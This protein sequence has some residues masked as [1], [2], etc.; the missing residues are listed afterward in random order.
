MLSINENQLSLYMSLFRGRSDVYAKRWQKGEKTWYM[1][2][3]SFNW[4]EYLRHKAQGGNFKNF[5]RKTK[6]PLTR[7]VIRRHLAGTHFIG[8]YPLLEDNTSYFIAADF[9]RKDWISDSKNFLGQCNLLGI[10]AYIEKSFSG[11]GAHLWIFFTEKYPAVKSRRIFLEIIRKALN[12]S[13]FAKQVSFDRVFPN[14]DYHS[15]KGFGNLIALPLNGKC[16]KEGRTLFLDPEDFQPVVDQWNYLNKINKVSADKLDKLYSEIIKDEEPI[17][18]SKRI[19]DKNLANFLKKNL[20]FINSEYIV[21]QKIGRSV[22]GI[23]KFFN[24]ITESKEFI[25][26]PRGFLGQLTTFCEENKVDYR[27]IDNRPNSGSIEFKSKIKLSK[28]QMQ[29]IQSCEH[30]Q[31]GV[32]VAP[33]G[34]GKTIIGIELIARKC[35]PSLIIVHRRQIYDQWIERIQDFL[36]LNK[37]DIGQVSSNKKKVSKLI[38]VAMIQSLKRFPGLKDISES[39]GTIIIDEC[40]HIPAKS[41]R[42]TIVNFNPCYIYGLTATPKRKYNDEKMIFFYIGDIICNIEEFNQ[43]TKDLGEEN[44]QLKVRDTNLYVPYDNKTD[45]FQILSKILIF[46]TERNRLIAQDIQKELKPGKRIL[47]LTERKE[48]VEVLGMYLKS[49]CEIITLTGDDS[50]SARKVKMKQVN[51]GNFQVLITTGQLLGEGLDVNNL[52][53]L[54]LVFPF[55]FEGKLVQYIGRILRTEGKKLVC[56]Y[57]DKNIGFL[58]KLYKKRERYY[59]KLNLI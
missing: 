57:K 13:E 58:L 20:N 47:I 5:N 19:T 30:A 42:K 11:K 29:V 39:F 18:G 33:P 16:L 10:P 14:Q 54:F 17:A 51:S 36:G 45:D 43:E 37:K 25:M 7:E 9:D 38:T 59:R 56:D 8:I 4:N 2:A 34:F 52:S 15:G 44:I 1:P 23:E 12:L 35:K 53:C 40:H 24:L 31:S 50:K 41:F 3:Y 28:P 48:H 55:A 32:I 22:Y 49:L 21:K 6:I 27:I 46:D 26:I